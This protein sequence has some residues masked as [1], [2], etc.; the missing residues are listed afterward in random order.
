MIANYRL[1]LH[2]TLSRII[3]PLMKKRLINFLYKF[4]ILTTDFLE[5]KNTTDTMFS[6]L[7]KVY[8]VIE[9]YIQQQY[10]VILLKHSIVLFSSKLDFNEI[11]DRDQILCLNGS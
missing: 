6:L 5:N 2:S 8:T 11:G 1:A 4:N 10:F 9:I 7:N 3:E